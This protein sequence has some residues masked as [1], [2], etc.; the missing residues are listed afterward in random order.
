MRATA[1]APPESIAALVSRALALEGLRLAELAASVGGDRPDGGVHQKGKVG[2]LL[3][4]AL[5]ATGG[6]LARVD[7]PALGVELKTIPVGKD[8]RPRESTFV[9]AVRLDDAETAEWEASW[10]RRKLA[11]VLWVPI[12]GDTRDAQR[13]IGRAVLWEPTAGQEDALRIDF[14]EVMGLVGIGRVEDITAH[15]GRY[16]QVRPKARDGSVRTHAFGRDGERIPT[17]PRGFYLRP[18]FTGA[19]LLDAAA[20]P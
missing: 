8:G 10:V 14:E 18:T 13:E 19:L 5:G 4:R 6:S 2:E 7:F 20:L 11:R 15:I 12:L 1:A 16:L 9:C 3:E 17:V